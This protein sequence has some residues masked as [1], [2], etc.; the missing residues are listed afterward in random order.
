MW[1]H[2][3]QL[4]IHLRGSLVGKYVL[5]QF[6]S[7]DEEYAFW[8]LTMSL[9]VQQFLDVAFQKLFL[10]YHRAGHGAITCPQT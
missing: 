8:L 10:H 5:S 3:L 4:T 6:G 9:E 1:H 7:L 2:V